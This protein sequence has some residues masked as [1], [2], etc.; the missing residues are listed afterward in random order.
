MSRDGIKDLTNKSKY[1]K[2]IDKE[3]TKLNKKHYLKQEEKYNLVKKNLSYQLSKLKHFSKAYID[4]ISFT[5]A[6]IIETDRGKINGPIST[7]YVNTLSGHRFTHYIPDKYENTIHMIGDSLSFCL[8]CEDKHTISSYLQKILNKNNMN[9]AVINSGVRGIPLID[10]YIKLLNTNLQKGDIVIIHLL[11]SQTSKKFKKLLDKNHLYINLN[12]L[13]TKKDIFLD[14]IHT[15]YIANKYIAKKIYS[16]LSTLVNFQNKE[17]TFQSKN[18]LFFQNLMEK[19]ISKYKNIK[20]NNLLKNIQL[21]KYLKN[22]KKAY[23]INKK[24]TVGSIVMNCNPFTLGHK[25]LIKYASSQ[26]D[27][28]FI[29]IL[30]EDKSYFKFKE[31]IFLV[32]EGV[33]N[34]TN[35]IVVKSGKFIISNHTFPEYFQ[36]DDLKSLTIDAS[37]DLDIFCNHIAPILNIT[38]R[39]AGDEPKCPIT[40]QYNNQMQQILP[41]YGIKFTKI[42]RKEFNGEVISASRVR[43]LLKSKDKTKHYILKNILPES[44]YQFLIKKGNKYVH[45]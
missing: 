17:L 9:Y 41:T 44:T 3:F 33:K 29:F 40:N 5:D 14:L 26:V 16:K 43:E 39:F 32:K 21:E 38:Q 42:K 22:L 6:T 23:D 34:L 10:V 8:G 18:S 35:V 1:H 24:E 2:K 20:E 27:K 15:N 13:N 30:E 37:Y 11:K 25:Y 19:N 12:N 31:R 36:K 28:L 45:K 7:P 4:N